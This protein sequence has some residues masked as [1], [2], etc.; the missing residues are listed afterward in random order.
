[1]PANLKGS[2]KS[3]N[4][5]VTYGMGGSKKK[6]MYGY[7]GSMKQKRMMAK[8]GKELKDIPGDNKGLGKL[9]KEVRNNMGYKMYGG[10][11]MKY[12]K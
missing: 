8:A 2:Y 9:P 7:G 11:S 3:K 12:K 6:P 10:S 1:M 5:M 4:G